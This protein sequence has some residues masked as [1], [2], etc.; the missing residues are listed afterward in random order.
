MGISK[1]YLLSEYFFTTGK[2]ESMIL[3]ISDR[4]TFLSIET[5]ILNFPIAKEMV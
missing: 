3:S 2:Q 1:L 4:I 5:H